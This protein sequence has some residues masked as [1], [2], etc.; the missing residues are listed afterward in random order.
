[1]SGLRQRPLVV[2]LLPVLL[3]ASMLTAGTV[4]VLLAA[5]ELYRPLLALVVA[6]SVTLSLIVF[7]GLL[8]W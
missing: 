6:A 5:K 8:R 3:L 7:W 4:A 1:M 2:L